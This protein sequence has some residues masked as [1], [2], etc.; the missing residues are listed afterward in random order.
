ML[1]KYPE[2]ERVYEG[3]T[4]LAEN[5]VQHNKYEEEITFSCIKQICMEHEII[6]ALLQNLKQYTSNYN[7]PEKACTNHLVVYQTLKEFSEDLV[8]H[9]HLENNILLPRAIHIEME[10]L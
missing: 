1:K 9:K 7:F 10:L 6:R 3:F 4:L 2:L 5:L 8:Q